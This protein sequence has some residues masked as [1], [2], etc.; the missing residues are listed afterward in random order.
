MSDTSITHKMAADG[1]RRQGD[2][3]RRPMKESDCSLWNDPRWARAEENM[4]EETREHYAKI[5]NQFNGGIDYETGKSA[6]IPIPAL[7]SMAYVTV[8]VKS[9]LT[10]DDLR[11][12]ERKLMCEFMGENWYEDILASIEDECSDSSHNHDTNKQ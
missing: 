10:K 12:D 9:G 2:I 1:K 7:E 6:E 8:G 11:E 4:G 3:S 5:G